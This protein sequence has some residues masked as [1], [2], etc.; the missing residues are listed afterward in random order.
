MKT[1]FTAILLASAFLS[2]AFQGCDK[3]Q[4][5]A[6]SKESLAFSPNRTPIAVIFTKQVPVI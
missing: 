2:S 4:E 1:L 3:L 6:G 5:N